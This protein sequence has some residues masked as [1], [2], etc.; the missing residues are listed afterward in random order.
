M[1][2]LLMKVSDNNK[3]IEDNFLRGSNDACRTQCPTLTGRHF[4]V[5]LGREKDRL[6]KTQD[7]KFVFQLQK[8]MRRDEVLRNLKNP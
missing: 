7:K 4:C 5:L 6:R 8:H 1:E 2:N 3:K